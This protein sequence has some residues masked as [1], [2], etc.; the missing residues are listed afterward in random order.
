V[1]VQPVDDGQ[2]TTVPEQP[3][4]RHR[5]VKGP[6]TPMRENDPIERL[7]SFA[8]VSLGYTADEAHTEAMRCLQCP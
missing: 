2:A 8:E 5:P 7:T 1:L 4:P 3:K 6:R